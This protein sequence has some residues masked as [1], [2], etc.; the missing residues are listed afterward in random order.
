TDSVVSGG[1]HGAN[2]NLSSDPTAATPLRLSGNRFSSQSAEAILGQGLFGQPVWI[3]DNR[4]QNAGTFGIRLVG[5][6]GLVLRNNN[7][8]GG[9]GG[10]NAGAAGYPA[11]YLNGVS[12]D[13]TSNVRGNV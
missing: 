2:I 10:P 13:F 8:T 12:A 7:I 5:A 9:G 3:T 1:V 11:A 6:D 4:M